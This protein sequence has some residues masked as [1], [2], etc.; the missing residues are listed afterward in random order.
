M[1]FRGGRREVADPPVTDNGGDGD[2]DMTSERVVS[3]SENRPLR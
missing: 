3:L 2:A 1:L